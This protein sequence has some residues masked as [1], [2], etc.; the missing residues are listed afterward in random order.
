VN[1]AARIIE[2]YGRL[3]EPGELVKLARKDP[4]AFRPTTQFTWRRELEPPSMD[5]GFVSVER[6]AFRRPA[7]PFGG[8]TRALIVELKVADEIDWRAW[9]A[10]GWLVVGTAWERE[11]P[12]AFD[13]ARCLHPAGPPVCWCRKP[14]P[15]LGLLL[16]R[17]HGID[18]ARSWHVGRGAADKGFAARL[19]LR[20]VDAADLPAP[21]PLVD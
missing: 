15:G 21:P 19:G 12:A 16:T 1:A 8:G 18:L 9:Q 20:F 5:E 7:M 11:A 13:V 6:V 4:S 14:L 10:A 2:T 17:R 3:P